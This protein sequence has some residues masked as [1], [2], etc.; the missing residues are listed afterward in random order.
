MASHKPVNTWARRR[1]PAR[2]ATRGARQGQKNRPLAK[3]KELITPQAAMAPNRHMPSR[4]VH[5]PDTPRPTIPVPA[6]ARR[7]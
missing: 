3:L 5:K 6:R 7:C 2:K 1:E 4:S